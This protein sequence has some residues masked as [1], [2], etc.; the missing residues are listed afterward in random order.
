[1]V[2]AILEGH[3]ISRNKA[4]FL[5]LIAAILW[6]TSGLFIKIIELNPFTIAGSRGIIAAL[7]MMALMNKRLN[8]NWSLPQVAG[9]LCYAGAMITF[10]VATV[11]TTAANAILLQYTMPVFTALFGMWLLKEKVTRFDWGV[12]FIVVGGMALFFLDELTLDGLW[13]NIIAI[14]SAIFFA[15]L[16]IFL[17]MQKSGSPVE[18]TILGNLIT[19]CICLP[20]IIQEPPTGTSLLPLS[21]LGIIQ[22]GL[23]FVLYS[24]AIKYV[25]AIDAVLIQ[26]IEPLLNPVWVFLIIGEEPGSWAIAGGAVVLITVTIRNIYTSRKATKQVPT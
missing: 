25:T 3:E 26:T 15:L 19:F 22:L 12:I 9:G 16:I 21:Y 23:P 24:A 7:M 5:V 11:M 10:V 17:R 18:T 13:G 4:I 2:T 1:M 6:S 14:I 8:F 20:F